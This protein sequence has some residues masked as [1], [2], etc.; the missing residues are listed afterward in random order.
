MQCLNAASEAPSQHT[1]TQ[2]V[3]GSSCSATLPSIGPP[4]LSLPDTQW[5]VVATSQS[6]SL[7]RRSLPWIWVLFAKRELTRCIARV[8]LWNSETF[9]II[10]LRFFPLPEATV[11]LQDTRGDVSF[12]FKLAIGKTN[13]I[14]RYFAGELSNPAWKKKLFMQPLVSTPLYFSCCCFLVLVH[15]EFGASCSCKEFNWAICED[16]GPCAIFR[17]WL[18]SVKKAIMNSSHWFPVAFS[19]SNHQQRVETRYLHIQQGVERR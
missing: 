17:F 15:C 18:L 12:F 10:H 7:N 19:W 1:H 9:R 6:H 14:V 3:D 11:L 4:P 13:G 16:S 2:T 8:S 5:Q